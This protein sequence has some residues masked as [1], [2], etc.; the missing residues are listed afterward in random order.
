M[1]KK[2]DHQAAAGAVQPNSPQSEEMATD[3]DNNGQSPAERHETDF[4]SQDCQLCYCI[5]PEPVFQ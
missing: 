3:P 5:S 2:I 1:Q 4:R